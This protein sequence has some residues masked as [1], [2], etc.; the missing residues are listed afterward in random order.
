M[1]RTEIRRR[2]Q[3][4]SDFLPPPLE[5]VAVDVLGLFQA[6]LQRTNIFGSYVL[7]LQLTGS[8][9]YQEAAT[10]AEDLI[11]NMIVSQEV[12]PLRCGENS[13]N[14]SVSELQELHHIFLLIAKS[15]ASVPT[16]L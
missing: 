11:E 14:S 2:G 15:G 3:F 8:P 16:D 10:I 12:P 4:V 1:R 6:M 5:R 13:W 7:Y 9:T